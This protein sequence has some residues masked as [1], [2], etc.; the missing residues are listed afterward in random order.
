VGVSH[1]FPDDIDALLVGPTGTNVM[2]MSDCGG[3]N[4][5]TTLTFTFDD[6]AA[7][8]LSDAGTLTSGT[9]KP[10][11]F[12]TATDL[13]PSPAPTGPNYGATLSLFNAQNPNGT[14][15]LYVRDDQASDSGSIASGWRLNITTATPVC[16]S[17]GAPSADLGIG[18]T[19]TP[20][21]TNVNGGI[22]FNLTITNVGPDSASSVTRCRPE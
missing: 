1:T 7:S 4:D 17:A 10:S 19:A 5:I 11:N 6:G 18:E 13:L 21:S 9:F 20:A 8:S 14:W 22:T 2:I 16:C 3:G 15:S 12:D